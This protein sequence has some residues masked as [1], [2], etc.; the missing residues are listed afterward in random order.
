MLRT[1]DQ[2]HLT[3]FRHCSQCGSDKV[4]PIANRPEDRAPLEV[5]GPEIVS[6]APLPVRYFSFKKLYRDMAQK[7]RKAKQ[8]A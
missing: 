5:K 6:I 1:C 2:G 8:A 3:G 7:I 4:Y